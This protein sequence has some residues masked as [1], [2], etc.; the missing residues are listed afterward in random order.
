MSHFDI[1]QR[2]AG[3]LCDD[4]SE[5][6]VGDPSSLSTNDQGVRQGNHPAQAILGLPIQ[7]ISGLRASSI[8]TY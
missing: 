8:V 3:F 5:I 4:R 1:I 6:I 2:I 7:A